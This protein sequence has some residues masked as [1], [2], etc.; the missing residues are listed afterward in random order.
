[1]KNNNLLVSSEL[2]EQ[3][4]GASTFLISFLHDM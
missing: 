1:M 4:L 2:Q 3:S